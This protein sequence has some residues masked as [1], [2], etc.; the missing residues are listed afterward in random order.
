[1]EMVEDESPKGLMPFEDGWK[2]AMQIADALEYAHEKGVIHRDLKPTNVK[3][4][5][6]GVVNSWISD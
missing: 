3:V 5:P 2:I 1:M 4:T 6:G